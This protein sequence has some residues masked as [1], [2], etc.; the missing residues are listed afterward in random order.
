MYTS[1]GM[2]FLYGQSWLHPGAGASTGAIDLPIQ[3]EVHTDYPV[4]PA[5]SVKGSLRETAERRA[6]QGDVDGLFGP[7]VQRSGQDKAEYFAGALTIGD[8]KLLL[9]PVRSLTRSF[10]WTTS[11]LALARFWRDLKMIGIE[12]GWD[13]PLKVDAECVM[14]PHECEIRSRLFL[15]EMDFKPQKDMMITEIAKFIADRFD[16]AVIGGAFIEKLKRDLAV[17]SDDEFGYSFV[18]LHK[19]LPE[20]S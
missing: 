9:F 1:K 3:R 4:I 14:V 15:E 17:L 7:E 18:T 11:P 13:A 20:F 2:L 12:P 5:S 16:A 6:S 10:F 19:F 8:A